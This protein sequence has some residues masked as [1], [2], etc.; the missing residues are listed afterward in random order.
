MVA[1]LDGMGMPVQ[2][3]LRRFA[4]CQLNEAGEVL[5][6]KTV[7]LPSATAA[8]QEPAMSE[9]V[10]FANE[11]AGFKAFRL[12]AQVDKLYTKEQAIQALQEEAAERAMAQKKPENQG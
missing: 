5:D 8:V 1:L 2:G 3:M 6:F 9:V 12:A 11:K 4:V 10:K 7:F